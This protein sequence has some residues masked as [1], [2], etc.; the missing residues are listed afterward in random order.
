MEDKNISTIHISDKTNSSKICICRLITV[1]DQGAGNSMA[2]KYII[3]VQDFSPHEITTEGSL[4]GKYIINTRDFTRPAKVIV[5]VKLLNLAI[6]TNKVTHITVS[7]HAIES[8]KSDFT[9]DVCVACSPGY[10]QP[11]VISSTADPN[12]TSCFK[13]TSPCLAEGNNNELGTQSLQALF[14]SF[15][16]NCNFQGHY[17]NHIS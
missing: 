15:L 7:G 17:R 6:N 12:T 8:C 4:A 9:R 11:D 10:V 3:N 5:A 2:N 16:I 13:P 1:S 14:I